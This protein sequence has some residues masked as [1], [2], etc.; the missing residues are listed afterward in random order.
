MQIDGIKNDSFPGSKN[1]LNS[2]VET[3]GSV[4]GTPHPFIWMTITLTHE[5]G[6]DSQS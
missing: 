6:A 2:G 3:N 4:K 1:S 5:P